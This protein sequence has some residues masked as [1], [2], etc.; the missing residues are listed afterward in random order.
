MEWKFVLL[1]PMQIRLIGL[2]PIAIGCQRDAP[3]HEPGP[4]APTENRQ[5]SNKPQDNVKKSTQ[6]N[7]DSSSSD[8]L[9]KENL[10]FIFKNIGWSDLLPPQ[11][12]N[13]KTTILSITPPA[14]V[15]AQNDF[16]SLIQDHL[17]N[18]EK[19]GSVVSHGLCSRLVIR[20]NNNQQHNSSNKP[21]LFGTEFITLSFNPGNPEKHTYA[22]IGFVV[23]KPKHSPD[24]EEH[25]IPFVQLKQGWYFDNHDCIKFIKIH[26]AIQL[27]SERG[28]IFV[29]QQIT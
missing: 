1:C 14:G 2:L 22:L 18:L 5:P 24:S 4:I 3:R 25:L 8:F 13:L 15:Y 7:R 16:S 10:A 26:E 27:A 19:T 11:L 9:Y 20:F 21:S 6:P 23:T 28:T 17:L 29:Y 12:Q